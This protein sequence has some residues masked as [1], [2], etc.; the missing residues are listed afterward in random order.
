LIHSFFQKKFPK[1]KNFKIH[2]L[3][4]SYYINTRFPL[5][6]GTLSFL[7]YRKKQKKGKQVIH[8]DKVKFCIFLEKR[9]RKDESEKTDLE[10]LIIS[11]NINDEKVKK[12]LFKNFKN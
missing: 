7:L 9:K 12:N 6:Y 2:N 1:I 8:K 4:L 11:Q 10:Y 3:S 5:V